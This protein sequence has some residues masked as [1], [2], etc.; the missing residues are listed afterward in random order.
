MGRRGWRFGDETEIRSR[1]NEVGGE[2]V[3]YDGVVRAD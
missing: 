2:L 3:I 1:I